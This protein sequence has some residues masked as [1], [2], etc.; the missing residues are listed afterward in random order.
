[1]VDKRPE[2]KKKLITYA[3]Y[4][5]MLKVLIKKI[6]KEFATEL[7]EK[8]INGVYGL[9]R[10]GLP[11]AVHFSHHLDLPFHT[12]PKEGCLIVDDISD[13]G[14]ALSEFKGKYPIVTVFCKEKTITK[15]NIYYKMV[16][17]KEWIVFP[18]EKK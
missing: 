8:K 18:W 2:Q 5:K 10:G 17:E 12:S 14:K 16:T 13:S 11:I 4:E 1:M 3:E 9:P 7:S 15:P 6:K